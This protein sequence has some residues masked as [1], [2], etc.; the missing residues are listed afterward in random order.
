MGRSTTSTYLVASYARYTAPVGTHGM[1]FGPSFHASHLLKYLQTMLESILAQ[2][3]A[4]GQIGRSPHSGDSYQEAVMRARVFWYAFERE[5]VVTALKG[6]RLV[7][8]IDDLGGFYQTLPPSAGPTPS[9]FAVIHALANQSHSRPFLLYQLAA[10][11]CDI[12]LQVTTVCHR[13]HALLLSSRARQMGQESAYIRFED[14]K[15]IWDGLDLALGTFE[16]LRESG[17]WNG[18]LDQTCPIDDVDAFVSGWQVF[19]FE[20]RK[21][22]THFSSAD[23]NC[24]YLQT[25]SFANHLGIESQRNHPLQHLPRVHPLHSPLSSISIHSQTKIAGSCFPP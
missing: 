15:A 5:G 25:M 16:S 23:S 10:R 7:M 14:M 24:C 17:L 13:I 8:Q 1:S 19:I 4:L 18:S 20:I 21:S 22:S 2:V 11:R 12:T 6:G 3:R 9:L